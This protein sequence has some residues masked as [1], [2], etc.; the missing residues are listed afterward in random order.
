MRQT[1]EKISSLL[2]LLFPFTC[3]SL[4]LSDKIF[5]YRHVEALQSVKHVTQTL[6][7]MKIS[8]RLIFTPHISLWMI[9]FFLLSDES[10]HLLRVWFPVW[11]WSFCPVTDNCCVVCL[12]FGF[13][14]IQSGFEIVKKRSLNTEMNLLKN[15][16][17][18]KK[19]KYCKFS[20]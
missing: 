1:E 10:R 13:W 14:N 4:K 9:F 11:K 5:T 2:S 15:L 17:W 3:W 8:E 18:L 16:F 12:Y 20:N 7:M 19:I 6:M